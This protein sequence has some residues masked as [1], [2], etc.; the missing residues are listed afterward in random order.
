MH[1]NA[2]IIPLTQLVT[3][4]LITC[5]SLS[6]GQKSNVGNWWMYF[7]NAT[8][9][10][11]F[12]WHHEV[13]YRN[14]N[15]IGDLEQLLVRTGLGY[16]LTETNANV[17]AGYGYIRS[18][19]YIKPDSSVF[20]NEHRT[21]QQFI[22]RQHFG[23]VTIQHRYRVEQRFLTNATRWRLR[24]FLAIQIPLNKP[25]V[26]KAAV[27]LSLYNEVFLHA[28][29]PVFDRNRVF[30][31]LGYMFTK[32]LRCELGYMTQI[33]EKTSRPQFQVALYNTFPFSLKSKEEHEQ[34][35]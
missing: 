3:L 10:N 35:N 2:R 8:L 30:G 19:R 16:N 29:V 21:F 17:L 22:M 32:S 1:R 24:Y 33:L 34:K 4:V 9:K 14:Y 5:F 31:A 6:Y 23:R 13:Q 18:Q 28:D 26:E 25:K 27:Y 12:N 7:G 11:R 15:M 20:T